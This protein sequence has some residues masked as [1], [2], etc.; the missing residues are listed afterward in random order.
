MEYYGSGVETLS[1][2]DRATI[3]NMGAELGVTT[4]VFPG[5]QDTCV[6]QK[7][8]GENRYGKEYKADTDA[9]Y[10]EHDEIDLSKLEPSLPAHIHLTTSKSFRGRRHSCSSGYCGVHQS[11][12]LFATS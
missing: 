11:T 7:A 10:D 4:T 3:A 9:E 8:R 2:T 12:L 5:S 1:V 6:S